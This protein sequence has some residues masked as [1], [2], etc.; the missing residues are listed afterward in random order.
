VLS[1]TPAVSIRPIA[2]TSKYTDASL[3]LQTAG[4]EMRVSN[5]V[6]GHYLREGDQLQVTLEAIDVEN[7]RTVWR[8]T[9]NLASQNLITV[10]DQITAKVRQ[11]L[12]PVLGG[13]A[14]AAEHSTRPRNEEAYDLFL[15]SIAM[16][17][18]NLPNKQA[19]SMLERAVGLDASYAPAWVELGK[20]YYDDSEYSD[21]GE[22]AYKRAQTAYQRAIVLDQD[23]IVAAS[24]LLEMQTEQGQLTAAYDEAHDLVQRHPNS[25]EAHFALSYI[26]RYAGLNTESARECDIALSLDPGYFRFRSCAI[27]FN[28]SGQYERALN[29]VALDAGSEWNLLVLPEILIRQGRTAEALQSL[30]S[31]GK[32]SMLRAC[33]ERRPRSEVISLAAK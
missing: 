33:L 18:D 4:R 6:T 5:I 17:H 26:L 3:D 2:T 21:G 31:S 32:G 11:G 24:S 28:L 12:V 10:R 13:S 8:D 7:N 27:T 25:A 16:P 14:A 15:R 23:L 29:Y 20:R 1:Y 9:L 19:I 30:Q 22:A